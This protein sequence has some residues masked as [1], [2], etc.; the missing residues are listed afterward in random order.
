MEIGVLGVHLVLAQWHVDQMEFKVEKGIVI[1]PHHLVD[2]SARDQLWNLYLV[3]FLHVEQVRKNTKNN[4][5]NYF[6]TMYFFCCSIWIVCPFL[7]CVQIV[8]LCTGSLKY[9]FL[10]H[11]MTHNSGSYYKSNGETEIPSTYC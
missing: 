6:C 7:Y 8:S 9:L 1:I 4:V 2:S 11:N 3:L 10:L 5:R